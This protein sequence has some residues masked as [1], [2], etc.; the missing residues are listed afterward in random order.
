MSIFRKIFF[1]C[2]MSITFS[3]QANY[4]P[5]AI[6]LIIKAIDNAGLVLEPKNLTRIFKTHVVPCS[7]HTCLRTGVCAQRMLEHVTVVDAASRH[8]KKDEY[9]ELQESFKKI[10]FELQKL[11]FDKKN[12]INSVLVAQYMIAQEAQC[13]PSG[14]AQAEVF[15]RVS[16]LKLANLLLK[17]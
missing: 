12:S 13:W 4:C 8:V 10:D 6:R 2:G 5:R 9:P 16:Y 17:K 11:P 14:S 7:H 3:T 1:I 15:K